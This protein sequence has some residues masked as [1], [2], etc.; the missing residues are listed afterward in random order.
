MKLTWWL[1]MFSTIVILGLFVVL[2]VVVAVSPALLFIYL[3][4]QK[5]KKYVATARK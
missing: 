5:R 2:T 3:I 1:A 4:F